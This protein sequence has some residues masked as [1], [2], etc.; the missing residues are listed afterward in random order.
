M[1]GLTV[2]GAIAAVIADLPAI[3]KDSRMTGGG[4]QYSYRGIEAIKA[5]L[6]PLLGKHGVHYAP[7]DFGPAEFGV[8]TTTSRQGNTTTWQ[9]VRVSV[10]FRIYGPDGSLVEA[11]GYGEGLD[12]SD[13][14]LNKAMTMAEKQMLIQVFCVSD[15]DPDPDHARPDRDQPQAQVESESTATANWVKAQIVDAIGKDNAKVWWEHINPGDGPF[16]M[17][18]ATHLVSEAAAWAHDPQAAGS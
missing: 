15:G 12:N 9:R 14:A 11:V 4:P 6:K 13:K 18:R 7:A 17:D 1:S 5:E 3:G 10:K 16:T 8:E 2:H